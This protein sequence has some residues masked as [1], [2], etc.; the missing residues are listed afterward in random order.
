MIRPVLDYKFG[1]ALE[2]LKKWGSACFD[3]KNQ[4][5]TL[6]QTG[7]SDEGEP[8]FKIHIQ[9]IGDDFFEEVE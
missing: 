8:E 9:A 6:T 4:H 5:W 3:Y 1:K 7:I 2:E